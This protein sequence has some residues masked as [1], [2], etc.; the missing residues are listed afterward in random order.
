M[1]KLLKNKFDD[2]DTVTFQKQLKPAALQIY[3]KVFPDCKLE[4]LTDEHILDKK[5]GIDILIHLKSGQ[6]VSMQEKYRKHHYLRYMDF[7]Q[8]YKNALGT[9]FENDGEW[10]HLASQLYFYGWSNKQETD[11]EKWFIMNTVKYKLL[12][13]SLGGIEKAGHLM[14][15]ST[16]GKAAFY[17]IKIS[18]IESCFITDYRKWL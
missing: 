13:E 4:Y 5:F 7:T 14:K 1:L 16:H 15:N 2:L 8:E 17:A 12:I 6:W 11:F 3:Q 10:F 18:T 9:D